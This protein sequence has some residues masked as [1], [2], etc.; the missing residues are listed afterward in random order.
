VKPSDTPRTDAAV[1]A[2]AILP[3][4][5]GQAYG[6]WVDADFARTL[7]RKLV[8]ALAKIKSMKRDWDV[9]IA[10]DEEALAADRA[11]ER[12]LGRIKAE[13]QYRA[14]AELDAK[15]AARWR[16]RMEFLRDDGAFLFSPGRCMLYRKGECVAAAETEQGAIDAALAKVEGK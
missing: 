9:A 11:V 13:D 4:E 1:V 5:T 10:Q 6:E 7:E 14:D 3:T 12:A 8:E 15:D 16:F 2:K